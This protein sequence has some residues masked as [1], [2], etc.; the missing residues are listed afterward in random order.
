MTG[1]HL[2]DTHKQTNTHTYKHIGKRATSST[3]EKAND[4]SNSQSD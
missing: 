2:L 1:E 3:E 4:Q